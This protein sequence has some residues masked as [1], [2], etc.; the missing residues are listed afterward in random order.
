MVDAFLEV[1]HVRTVHPDNAAILYNDQATT[2]TM[3]PNG[4]S[5]LTV[6]KHDALRDFPMVS[7]E[8]DNPAVPYGVSAVAGVAV[9]TLDWADNIEPEGDLSGYKVYRSTTSGSYDFGTPLIIHLAETRTEVDGILKD[10]G[11]TPVAYLA[12]LGILSERTVAAH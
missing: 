1:Y 12:D 8:H 5:R 2:V 11:V 10:K 3:L 7:D 4:H 9:V 6:E